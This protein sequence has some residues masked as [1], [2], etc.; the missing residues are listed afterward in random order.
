[1]RLQQQLLSVNSSLI[2]NTSKLFAQ[3]E[4]AIFGPQRIHKIHCLKQLVRWRIAVLEARVGAT[5][6]FSRQRRRAKPMSAGWSCSHQTETRRRML[7]RKVGACSCLRE[8]GRF[9]L[10]RS[11]IS[12]HPVCLATVQS[13]ELLCFRRGVQ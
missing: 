12:V 8:D 3:S 2:G 11:Q 5:A 10:S 9:D 13:T 1:M 4:A 7:S 6:G